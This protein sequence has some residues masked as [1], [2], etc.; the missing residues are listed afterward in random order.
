MKH[1]LSCF[2]LLLS[3][4]NINAQ[5]INTIYDGANISYGF[6]PSELGVG[7]FIFT[8]IY[9]SETNNDVYSIYDESFNKIKTITI[10]RY[11]YTSSAYLDIPVNVQAGTPYFGDPEGQ[12]KSGEWTQNFT[13]EEAKEHI[14]K[15]VSAGIREVIE[16]DESYIITLNSNDYYY[17]YHYWGYKY[18]AEYFMFMKSTSK[19][20]RVGQDYTISVE[21]SGQYTITESNTYYV[22]S[23]ILAKITKNGYQSFPM[24]LSQYL[25]NDDEKFEYIRPIYEIKTGNI[26]ST[27]VYRLNDK[28][29][30]V[31]IA[32]QGNSIITKGF[33]I[34]NEDNKVIASYIT[35]DLNAPLDSWSCYTEVWDTGS[36]TYIAFSLVGRGLI[37]SYDK[38]TSNLKM[39]A[40]NEG[41]RVSPTIANRSD[42]ITVE[43]EGE[44]KVNREVRVVN[45]AGQI[46]TRTTIPAG[47]NSVRIN[48]AELSHGLN[49]VNM[50]GQQNSNCKIIIK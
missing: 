47:Q 40:K 42:M 19:L 13:L 25:F 32:T 7:S 26:S 11:S 48:A 20:F 9:N 23:C 44:N 27:E 28:G 35:D 46:V 45:T 36:H 8:N 5:T 34:V 6:V 17:K 30:P 3:S 15:I 49:I 10:P 4:V 39:V 50:N 43:L 16:N 33:E 18:P 41:M 14:E 29:E 1:C 24:Q 31:V 12:Y 2:L 37:F 21:T 22:Y 38:T